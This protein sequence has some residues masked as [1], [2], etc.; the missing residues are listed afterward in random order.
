[1]C[2]LLR[3]VTSLSLSLFQ[4][5]SPLSIRSL[6]YIP[7]HR[8]SPLEFA[9]QN[10]YGVSLYARKVLIKPKAPELLPKYV[11][12][13][14]LSLTITSRYLR[15]VV[16]VVDSEDIPLNLSREMLQNDPI[17]V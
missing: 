10:E 13:F 1:M 3:T 7:S 17:L 12:L 16:G 15:F 4:A 14:S 9:S 8:V 6:L 5:D 2:L 11:R